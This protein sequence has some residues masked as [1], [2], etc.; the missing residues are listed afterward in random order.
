[1]YVA[2]PAPAWILLA[3]NALLWTKVANHSA[4]AK[5]YGAA[6]TSIAGSEAHDGMPPRDQWN[7]LARTV[8]GHAGIRMLSYGVT[9]VLII[10][11]T[12]P[13]VGRG[14]GRDDGLVGWWC[15]ARGC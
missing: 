10:R 6:L 7:R 1:M 4:A 14:Y 3:Y 2:L 11:F 8:F 13:T 12:A 15:M 9:F 5:I